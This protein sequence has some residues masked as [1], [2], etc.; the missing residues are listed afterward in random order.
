ME[1]YTLKAKR[2]E[3]G[4]TQKE[5]A[6]KVGITPNYLISVEMGRVEP[7]RN[8]MVKIAKELDADVTELFFSEDKEV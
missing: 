8:L 3:K 4:I 7:R 1:K 2:V 6:K 5:F